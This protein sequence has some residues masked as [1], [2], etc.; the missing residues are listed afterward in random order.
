MAEGRCLKVGI[1]R[2]R[3]D[4]DTARVLKRMKVMNIDRILSDKQD[5]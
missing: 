2:R 3:L 5:W 4:K 1:L